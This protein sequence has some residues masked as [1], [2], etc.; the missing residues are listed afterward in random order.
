MSPARTSPIGSR[1]G[2]SPPGAINIFEGMAADTARLVPHKD[3]HGLGTAPVLEGPGIVCV[4]KCRVLHDEAEEASGRTGDNSAREQE[5]EAHALPRATGGLVRVRDHVVV[6]G[7][8]LDIIDGHSGNEDE[9]RKFGLLYADRHYRQL[10]ST[11][12]KA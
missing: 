7:E 9:D 1:T 12:T 3:T 6:F 5:D 2:T 4:M 8:V 11:L 10:G